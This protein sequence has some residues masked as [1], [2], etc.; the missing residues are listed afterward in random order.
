MVKPV[1]YGECP[2]IHVRRSR[3]YLYATRHIS[4]QTRCPYSSSRDCASP[5]EYQF[6]A[7]PVRKGADVDCVT[8]IQVLVRNAIATQPAIYFL[9]CELWETLASCQS[10]ANY[11]RKE[12]DR[13]G[14]A[15]AAGPKV[16]LYSLET[17]FAFNDY[18][19]IRAK[20]D[21][22]LL[23]QLACHTLAYADML[24]SW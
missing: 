23:S 13:R 24:F 4:C 10:E 3:I 18:T 17:R 6:P 20:P 9:V 8:R 19:A 14:G 11:T 21:P 16:C 5:A 15:P 1:Q 22:E 12:A 7:A 2:P